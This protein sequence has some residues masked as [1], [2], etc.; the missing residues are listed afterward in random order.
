MFKASGGSYRRKRKARAKEKWI[1]L[2]VCKTEFRVGKNI[3]TSSRYYIVDVLCF[4]C[5][6][7]IPSNDI[8]S[9]NKRF[10]MN[11]F[12]MQSS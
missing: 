8:V 11:V 4:A 9:Q 10:S 3:D 12:V 1:E 7:L 2:K 6:D 5:K